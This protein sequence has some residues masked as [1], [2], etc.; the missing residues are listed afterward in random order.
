MIFLAITLNDEVDELSTLGKR[1]QCNNNKNWA[2]LQFLFSTL[3]CTHIKLWQNLVFTVK[4]KAIIIILTIL[5][6]DYSERG[7]ELPIPK[8]MTTTILRDI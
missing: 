2:K 6:C 5:F 8:R 4:S 1:I 3:S 7:R